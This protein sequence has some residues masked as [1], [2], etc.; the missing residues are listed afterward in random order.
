MNKRL[1]L[2][3]AVLGFVSFAEM[4]SAEARGRVRFSSS[5]G[6]GRVH[7]RVHGN[8]NVSWNRG[9]AYRSYAQRPYRGWGTGGRVYVGGYRPYYGYGYGYGYYRPYSYYP[10]YYYYQ[11]VPSY[12]GSY[13][14]VEAAPQSAAP[15]VVAAVAPR[16][17]L[18]KFGIGVFAGGSAVEDIEESSDMGLLGRFRLT[19]GL[20]IEGE[21]GK[22]SYAD[23]LRVDRRLGASLVY[24]IGAYNK[25]A[26]YVLGG[27]GVQQ[28]DVGGGEF[29]TTQNF[30]EIGV[31]LR[32]ALSPNVH[33]LFDVRAGSRQTM[34]QQSRGT[35]VVTRSITPPSPDA[36]DIGE[37]YTRARL[38]AML[39]F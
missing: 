35:G 21:I 12:Y 31:G 4:D 25:L 38:A 6:G 29:T 23:D 26:P 1:G 10:R 8:V 16:P 30:A 3:V 27:L 14:P 5:G 11:P 33:V 2:L 19:P 7:A 24:E 15:A 32:Y 39:Y 13:Y 37:Q 36:D 34:S 18:P 22:T 20:L 9:G 28:A 17:E